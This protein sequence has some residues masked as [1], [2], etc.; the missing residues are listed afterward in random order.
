METE[1]HE[2]KKIGQR[3]KSARVL[4]GLNQEEFA[5][6]QGFN[7]TSLRNWEFGRVSP[8]LEAVNKLVE[9]FKN[10]GV[11]VYPEWILSGVGEGPALTNS[12]HPITQIPNNNLL[13]KTFRKFVDDSG[14][15]SIIVTVNNDEMRPLFNIGDTICGLA[16]TIHELQGWPEKKIKTLLAKPMLVKGVNAE[17]QP[18]WLNFDGKVW[19]SRRQDF[20][21]APLGSDIIGII[22]MQIYAWETEYKS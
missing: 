1:N 9:S 22:K 3:I 21:L 13:I 4:T 20:S 19:W 18:R 16:I 8:R 14:G 7:Y 6:E 11:F 12:E 5:R 17:F 2:Q 10:F 15:K